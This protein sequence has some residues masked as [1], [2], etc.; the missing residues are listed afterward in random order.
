[1]RSQHA[2]HEAVDLAAVVDW[3]PL[4]R[5]FSGKASRRSTQTSSASTATACAALL[6]LRL[7]RTS[8][9]PSATLTVRRQ[10]VCMDH[11]N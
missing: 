1:M 9:A 6:S 5:I 3:P 2:A 7:A 11:A 10:T 8:S 4:R